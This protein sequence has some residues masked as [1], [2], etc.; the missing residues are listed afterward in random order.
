MTALHSGSQ[1][2]AVLALQQ[3][4]NATGAHLLLDGHYG[5]ATEAA[6]RFY[7]LQ[8]PP[9]RVDGVAGP[10]TL[11]ALATATAD[12]PS[13][14]A[15]SPALEVPR[16][17][18][19]LPLPALALSFRQAWTA[20]FPSVPT[21]I[22]VRMAVAHL[23][24]EHG[25]E[26]VPKG[27]VQLKATY[28]HNLGNL[29]TGGKW[30][31]HWFRMDALEVEAGREVNHHSHWRAFSD[32]TAGVNGYLSAMALSFPSML[33]AFGLGSPTAVATAGKGEGYFT[34]SIDVY[35]ARLAACYEAT[36][37]APSG[38]AGVG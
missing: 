25:V 5:P 29:M 3:A 32:P 18:T 38:A 9:L 27:D 24:F 13:P 36:V 23:R 21:P 34:A 26:T 6:V 15:P 10:V 33:A 16:V 28:C 37:L 14:S 22:E 1:G 31:G 19:P 12:P 30:A 20:R 7:Q 4:L 8:R 2:P 35:A 11:A 17:R